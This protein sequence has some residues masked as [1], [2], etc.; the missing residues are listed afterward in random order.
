VDLGR[1]PDA[2]FRLGEILLQGRYVALAADHLA[3]ASEAFPQDLR[4][5]QALAAARALQ[6]TR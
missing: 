5:R 2:H 3:R 4:L 1:G 6:T